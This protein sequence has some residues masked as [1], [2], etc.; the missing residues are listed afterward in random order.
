MLRAKPYAGRIREVIWDL[1]EHVDRDVH[2]LLQVR[3]QLAGADGH[4]IDEE[5]APGGQHD[6]RRR[7]A[8][9]PGV[10][11]GRLVA[12]HARRGHGART[13][14][15]DGWDVVLIAIKDSDT[16]AFE[17]R[18]DYVV[19]RVEL[20]S[21]RLPRW[22][23]PLRFFEAIAKTFWAAYREDADVYDPR[24]IYPMFVCQL[25]AWLRR[26]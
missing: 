4:A 15:A 3:S 2:P 25:A 6:V 10:R 23:R 19:K 12:L 18:G 24:D 20:R 11:R 8:H 13:L 5:I 21:R 16:P 9:L 26:G 14:A 1:A 22:T 17:D 7:V